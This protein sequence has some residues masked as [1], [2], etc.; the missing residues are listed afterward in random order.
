MI[1]ECCA[2]RSG[3]AQSTGRTGSCRSART[4]DWP[5]LAA[6]PHRRRRRPDAPR[7]RERS[8]LVAG[9]P[10][11]TSSA[12]KR[13][14]SGWPKQT[15]LGDT[16]RGDA[17][18]AAVRGGTRRRARAAR[19]QRRRDL[20]IVPLDL[21]PQQPLQPPVDALDRRAAAGPDPAARRGAAGRGRDFLKRTCREPSS[22][23]SS[24]RDGLVDLLV[25]TR[26][27]YLLSRPRL[28]R[29]SACCGRRASS[30]AIPTTL[31]GCTPRHRSRGLRQADPGRAPARARVDLLRHRTQSP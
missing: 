30:S 29:R 27:H 6:S 12:S 11:S 31:R 1:A 19:Q 13:S 24:A 14:R 21:T 20:V 9:P 28:R 4:R 3:G 17:H 18:A 10:V 23:C 2:A 15:A 8:A 22:W 25:S 7:H 16:S 5:R 26:Y